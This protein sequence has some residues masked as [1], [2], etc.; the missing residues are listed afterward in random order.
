MSAEP[1]AVRPLTVADLPAYKALRDE[2][3][4]AHP[5]AF[6]SDAATEARKEPAEY[7]QRLGVGRREGGHFTLGA[8]RG[9]KLMGAIGCEREAS[10][11][12]SHIGHVIGMM[13]RPEARGQGIGRAL[14]ETTIAEARRAGLETLM[15]TVTAGNASAVAL[16]E[17]S[18]FFV[19]G[20]LARA[21]KIGARYHDKLHMALELRR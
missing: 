14:L 6:T 17:S 18:G 15:L 3:L 4:F 12:M 19:W 2:M 21:L 13:V 7:L 5:E 1:A 16:Y 9:S 11:K 20:T 10:V 8:W